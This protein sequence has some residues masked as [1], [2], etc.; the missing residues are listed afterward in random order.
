MANSTSSSEMMCSRCNCFG[1][2]AQEGCIF[3]AKSIAER[4]AEARAEAA[5]RRA[6]WEARQEERAKKL[7][8][9]EAKQAE[10]KAKR[11]RRGEQCDRCFHC[12]Q[13]YTRDCR[14]GGGG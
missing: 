5:K 10:E 8:E 2:S 14:R 9:W 4:R 7:A 3:F 12:S 13:H 6:A 1:H 11:S